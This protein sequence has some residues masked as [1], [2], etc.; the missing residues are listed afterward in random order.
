MPAKGGSG[1][2]TQCT[3]QKKERARAGI[4]YESKRGSCI[5]IELACYQRVIRVVLDRGPGPRPRP[6]LLKTK[7]LQII[8]LHQS[9][10]VTDANKH[11]SIV[12]E[13]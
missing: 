3:R 5:L 11:V 8:Q 1:N 6:T 7:V 13:E 2:K 9:T 10:K 4:E 12:P